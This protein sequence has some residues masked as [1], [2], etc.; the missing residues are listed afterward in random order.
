MNK[1]EE[2]KSMEVL[3]R[4]LS[5]EKNVIE[6]MEFEGQQFAIKNNLLARNMHPS[7]EEYEKLGFKFYDIPGDDVLYKA[8]LPTGWTLK[9]TNNSMHIN[10]VD[11]NGLTRGA[12]FY[13]SSFYDRKASMNLICRFKITDN[14]HR[15]SE[16]FEIWFGN[17]QEKLFVAGQVH[18]NVTASREERERNFALIEK[19]EAQAKEFADI[20]YPD[21]KNV[22]AYWDLNKKLDKENIQKVLK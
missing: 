17:E 2:L 15:G 4:T 21:W 3:L 6:N 11:N 14:Y 19:L 18:S 1:K 16:S 8:T 22:N 5:G 7:K 20:N 12:M 9:A 10:I 13:K